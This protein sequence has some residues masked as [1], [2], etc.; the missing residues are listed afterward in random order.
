MKKRE[1][2]E[3][4]KAWYEAHRE[5]VRAR[6]KAYYQAHKEQKRAKQKAWNATHKQDQKAYQKA[7]YEAHKQDKKAWYE[8]HKEQQLARMKAWYEAH[9]Q[10]KKAW[11]EAN[12]EQQRAK[13]KAWYEANKER[14][15]NYKKCNLNSLGKT[16]HSIRSKSCEIL[17][18]MN[19]KLP[20]YEIHHCFGYEDANRFIYISKSL[21]L[22]IHQYLRDHNI[23]ADSNHWMQIRDIVNAADEFTYIRC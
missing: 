16:K 17:K 23:S 10:D 4:K 2:K 8:A 22:K 14:A 18:K 1:R 6:M 7:W 21:H 13:N 20:D 3:Y 19:L 5:Q 15:I 12:K 11:Y 9:K